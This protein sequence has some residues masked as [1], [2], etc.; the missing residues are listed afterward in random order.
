MQRQREIEREKGDKNKR[1]G[2][3]WVSFKRTLA[4]T[5]VIQGAFS[6]VASVEGIR[7]AQ[8]HHGLSLFIL[9]SSCINGS[10]GLSCLIAGIVFL[11]RRPRLAS[12]FIFLASLLSIAYTI[13]AALL[14]EGKITWE[15]LTKSAIFLGLAGFYLLLALW[16]RFQEDATD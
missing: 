1:G 2:F 9:L 5:F 11:L 3:D 12:L 16:L 7:I 13:V 8:E 6:A 15:L 14:I 10:Q 4:V